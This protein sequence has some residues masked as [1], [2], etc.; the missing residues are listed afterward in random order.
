MTLSVVGAV[1]GEFVAA[2]HGLGYL[3]YTS[4]AYFHIS[5]AFGAMII[6]SAIGLL[7]FQSIVWIEQFAFPWSATEEPEVA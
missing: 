2:E 4:T 3:I 1:V 6:L 7:L 5:I